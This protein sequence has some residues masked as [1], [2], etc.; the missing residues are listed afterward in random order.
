MLI[1]SKSHEKKTIK[2]LVLI[3]VDFEINFN[4]KINDKKVT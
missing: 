3:V 2:R 4:K 1:C